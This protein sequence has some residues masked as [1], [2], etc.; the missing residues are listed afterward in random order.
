MLHGTFLQVTFI[1]LLILL[2][3]LALE[4]AGEQDQLKLYNFFN[5]IITAMVSSQDSTDGKGSRFNQVLAQYSSTQPG[6][7]LTLLQ[8]CDV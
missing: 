1:A 4:Y 7:Q 8:Y 2:L 5:E 3:F 6:I